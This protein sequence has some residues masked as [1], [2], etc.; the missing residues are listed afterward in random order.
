MCSVVGRFEEMGYCVVVR[1]LDPDRHQAHYHV[2][3]FS[4]AVLPLKNR[5]WVWD[6]HNEEENWWMKNVS[7]REMEEHLHVKGDGAGWG[8]GGQR[9]VKTP[10]G[11]I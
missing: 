3:I 4:S 10:P 8:A 6:E 5:R 9:G 1:H 7:S 2:S 11:P